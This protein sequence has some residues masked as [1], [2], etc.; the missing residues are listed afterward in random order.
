[1]SAV[2]LLESL[3]LMRH[4]LG[5]EVRAIMT[6]AATTMVSPRSIAVITGHSVALDKAEAAGSAVAHVEAA[7]WSELML[8]IPA[9]ADVVT[10]AAHGIADDLLMKAIL[11]TQCP[12]VFAPAMNAGMWSKADVQR[13]L[14]TLRS[15]GCEVIP[16]GPIIAV[17]DG[18]MGGAG[19]QAIDST[20]T[21]IRDFLC[22][23]R[24]GLDRREAVSR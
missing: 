8:V 7:T 9:T 17:S 19:L 11:A 6:R 18:D 2:G 15:D 4:A 14:A 21:W 24:A 5:L 13:N 23:D 16:P 10:G 3:M 12:V 22:Q 1:M 20:L